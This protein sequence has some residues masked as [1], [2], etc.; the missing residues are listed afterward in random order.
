MLA[1]TQGTYERSQPCEV[2]TTVFLTLRRRKLRHACSLRQVAGGL[3]S[4][5]VQLRAGASPALLLL[6]LAA[7][8]V[9][10][11]VFCGHERV[12]ATD[13]VSW[14]ASPTLPQS[15]G[16]LSLPAAAVRAALASV[17]ATA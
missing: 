14:D 9:C 12:I 7:V 4:G 13:W 5:S 3:C 17:V 2:S 11:G 15:S 6:V 1:D 8:R 16:H 10:V